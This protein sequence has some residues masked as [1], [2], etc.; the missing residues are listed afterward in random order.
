RM[1]SGTPFIANRLTGLFAPLIFLPVWLLPPITGLAVLYFIH[2]LLGAWFMYLFL[3][4]I[5]LSRPAAIFGAIAYI[6]QGTYLPVHGFIVAGKGYMPM[7]FYYLERTCSRRDAVGIVGAILSFNFLTI[8]SYPQMSVF[9]LYIASGWVLF[10][11]GIGIGKAM[12]RGIGLIVLLVIAFLIG[13]MQ[14]LTMLEFFSM[15]RRFEGD[16]AANLV[17]PTFLERHYNLWGLLT[18]MFPRLWGDYISNPDSPL[19]MIVLR[20][21]NHAYIGIL[22]A[23]GFLFFGIVW[24]NKYAKFFAIVALIGLVSYAW[25]GFYDFLVMVLPGF[26]I[27]RIRAGFPTFTAMII[28]ASFVFDYILLNLRC[29]EKLQRRIKQ[30]F[31]IFMSAI[32]G[33]SIL[34]VISF[35]AKNAYTFNDTIRFAWILWG[36]AIATAASSL[37]FFH[38]T[39][40]LPLKWVIVSIIALQLID[41]VPYHEHFKPMI[42]KG[43]TC[44]S[45]PCIEFLAE[46][47]REEG[48]FRIFRDRYDVLPPNTPMLFDIDE[49]G[50][51]D[52][53]LSSDYARLFYSIDPRMTEDP[54]TL[55]L[56]YEYN[57]FA[58][59]LW[60]FLGVRYLVLIRNDRSL[61][62]PWTLV[63]DR[64][65]FIYENPEWMPRWYLVPKIL[66]VENLDD[67][68]AATGVI[69]PEREAVVVD[70]D[71][72]QIPLSLLDSGFSDHETDTIGALICES[73]KANELVLSVDASRDCFLVF[74]DTYF[75]G[76]KAWIDDEEVRIY[77]ANAVVK[78][79]VMPEGKHTVRFL[80]DP[81]LY[82]LGWWLCLAGWILMV[83]LMRPIQLLFGMPRKRL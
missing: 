60:S 6:L 25:Q 12:K 21:Y 61:P 13:A 10:T 52:S 16:F 23:F 40:N 75:P 33:M 79:I 2:Y 76:W 50:G 73:Y 31:A 62:P 81:P 8:T 83:A 48:P 9:V 38:L 35:F 18:I 19:P 41:L 70:I 67:A 57:G 1:F 51:Y 14:H 68:Y 34:T 24:K 30:A 63:F 66:P 53:F 42:P 58:H 74:A 65:Q 29:D 39:R 17:A 49:I 32:L 72:A 43:R 69:R 20:A 46:K 56:P 28:V 4:C 77:R 36:I 7:C 59:P 64:D 44:F 15:S 37:F 54:L 3:K 80:Y 11:R 71:I 5:G 22:A 82:K 55:F 45:T 26:R 78:G 27:S 47:T